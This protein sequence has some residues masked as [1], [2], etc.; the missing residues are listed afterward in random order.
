MTKWLWIGAAALATVAAV[1]VWFA[2]QSPGFVAGLSA[3]AASAAWKAISPT[4]L[5][6]SLETQRR[7]QEDARRAVERDVTGRERER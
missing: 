1:S 5:K 2:F 3:I 4:I 6:S 7:A